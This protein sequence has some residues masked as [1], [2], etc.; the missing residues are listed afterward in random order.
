MMGKVKRRLR[1]DSFYGYYMVW[2]ENHPYFSGRP[3]WVNLHR[4]RMSEHLNREL[5]KNEIVHHKN[6]IKTDNRICN[7]EVTTRSEHVKMH[8][9]ELESGWTIEKAIRHGESVKKAA[10]LPENRLVR[11]ENAKL[12]HRA[13]NFGRATWSEET[14][15]L[16]GQKISDSLRGKVGGRKG[17]K[18]T[19]EQRERYR[20]AAIKREAEKRCMKTSLT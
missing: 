13:G 10:N 20:I 11:S 6:G 15:K 19:P 5:R 2:V 3:R 9:S 16:V 12:Q 4:V 17:V 8:R 7:L 18:A 1:F 14:K